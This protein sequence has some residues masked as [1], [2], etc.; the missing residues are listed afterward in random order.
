MPETVSIT[1]SRND[2]WLLAQLLKRLTHA[3]LEA[4]SQDAAELE[5]MQ[6]AVTSTQRE[7]AEA[8]CAPR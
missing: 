6:A 8:G 7:L 4:C 5:A 2:A 3:E 1:L